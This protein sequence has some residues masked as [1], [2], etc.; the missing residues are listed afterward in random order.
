[1]HATRVRHSGVASDMPTF[2]YVPSTC[3]R[4]QEGKLSCVQEATGNPGE[5]P[6]PIDDSS[7]TVHTVAII[8]LARPLCDHPL[9]SAE[10]LHKHGCEDNPRDVALHEAHEHAQHAIR[11]LDL[12][13]ER[14]SHLPS[15]PDGDISN[16]LQEAG[17][18]SF[19]AV[20]LS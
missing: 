7:S 10:T 8:D 14:D 6:P 16:L 20:M 11:L 5:G 15:G 9:A 18:D 19:H 2:E 12:A 13:D 3:H 17:T 1:M 4:G